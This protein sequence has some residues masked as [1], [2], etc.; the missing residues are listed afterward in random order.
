MTLNA[1]ARHFQ[2][3]AGQCADSTVSAGYQVS[4]QEV[5][6]GNRLFTAAIQ[7]GVIAAVSGTNVQ[8][9]AGS[10]GLFPDVPSGTVCFFPDRR[11][12]GTSGTPWRVRAKGRRTTAPAI[13]DRG[14]RSGEGP[15]RRVIRRGHGRWKRKGVGARRVLSRRARGLDFRS[16]ARTESP[17]ERTG[18]RAQSPACISPIRFLSVKDWEANSPTAKADCPMASAV[19]EAIR[20]TSSMLRLISSLVADC[21][22]E[23]VAMERT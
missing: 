10:R 14:L 17:V 3:E 22:S 1:Y 4:K 5:I 12:R 7:Q 20:L 2:A 18:A 19:S 23:A 11:P 9:S 21:C 15:R 13:R 16:R 6:H 8:G